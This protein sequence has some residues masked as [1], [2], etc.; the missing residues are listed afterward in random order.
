MGTA[1]IDER[2]ARQWLQGAKWAA[3][4][5]VNV[6]SPVLGKTSQACSPPPSCR[7][8]P[9][10]ELQ[11]CALSGKSA[12]TPG[13]LVVAG[14]LAVCRRRCVCARQVSLERTLGTVVG[15]LIGLGVVQLGDSLGPFLSPT[16]TAFTSAHPMLHLG[17]GLGIIVQLG[18][19]LGPFLSP[20][21]TAFTSAHPIIYLGLELGIIVQVGHSLGP[22]LSKQGNAH[23]IMDACN[24]STLEPGRLLGWSQ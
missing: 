21:D 7:R 20:T 22:F 4:T 10:P 11:R 24:S 12:N 23:N 18:D 15:G 9:A 13:A 8:S 16:D 19:S 3:I 5:I 2:Y 14:P 6:G 1:G 17:L